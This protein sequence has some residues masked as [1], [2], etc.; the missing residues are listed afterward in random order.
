MTNENSNPMIKIELQCFLP[1]SVAPEP[2][3]FLPVL[4]PIAQMTHVSSV[5]APLQPTCPI[6]RRQR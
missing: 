6:K 5:A 2:E 4:Q 1:S 3:I